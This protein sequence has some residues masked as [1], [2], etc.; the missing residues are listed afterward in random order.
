MPHD[1][2]VGD[3]DPGMLASASWRDN[4]LYSRGKI[5]SQL[6]DNYSKYRFARISDVAAEAAEEAVP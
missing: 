1:T 6:V 2:M 3:A 4:G 5:P